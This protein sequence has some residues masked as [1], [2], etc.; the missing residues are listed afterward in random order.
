MV[1]ANPILRL[2]STSTRVWGYTSVFPPNSQPGI[3]IPVKATL[4]AEAGGG[5]E[6]EQLGGLVDVELDFRTVDD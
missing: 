5:F 6:V 2:K 4:P 3:F 1:I